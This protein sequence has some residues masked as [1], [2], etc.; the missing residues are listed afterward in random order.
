MITKKN[1]GKYWRMY[2]AQ[3]N[4]CNKYSMEGIP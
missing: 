2:F 4:G 1:L 3:F